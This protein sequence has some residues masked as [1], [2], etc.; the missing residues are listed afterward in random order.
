MESNVTTIPPDVVIHPLTMAEYLELKDFI[1]SI[2]ARLPE[3]KMGYVWNMYNRIRGVNE[4]QPCGC[5]SAAKYWVDAI[6]ELRRWV[7]SKSI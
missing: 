2:G 1:F 3:Q 4:K 6:N 7:E 5:Q